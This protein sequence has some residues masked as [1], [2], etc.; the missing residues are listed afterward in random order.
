M[1]W[2]S[3][4]LNQNSRINMSQDKLEQLKKKYE[5][6][7]SEIAI[8][9][10]SCRFPGAKNVA[11]FWAN[12]RDGKESLSQVSAED[13]RR[14]GLDPAALEAPG[15]VAAVPVLDDIEHFDA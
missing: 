1:P 4:W 7:G 11:E 15:Y 8:I 9:G 5:L 13:L 10:M 3:R 12:L 6:N 2:L 14:G